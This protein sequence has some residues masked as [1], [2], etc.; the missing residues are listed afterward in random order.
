MPVGLCN[1]RLLLTMSLTEALILLIRNQECTAVS[2]GSARVVLA[3]NYQDL[4]AL[5]AERLESIDMLV[6]VFL[7]I[8]SADDRIDL[9]LDAILPAPRCNLVQ[10]CH[11]IAGSSTNLDVGR[12]HHFGSG[13][14]ILLT[15]SSGIDCKQRKP[16][17]PEH[18]IARPI[19]HT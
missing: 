9:E 13:A 19:D 12:I 8:E 5:P 7:I 1:K 2:E 4:E 16:S 14:K 3:C 18:T 10:L 17:I 11:L 6:H 15:C